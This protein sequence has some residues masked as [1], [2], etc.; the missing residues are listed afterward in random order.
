M[1]YDSLLLDHDGVL[2]SVLDSTTRSDAFR[3][4]LRR[5]VNEADIEIG[6]E[7]VIDT[8]DGGPTREEVLDLGERLGCDPGRLWTCRDEA[9]A[10]TLT[11]AARN[12]QK[13]PY[14]DLDAVTGLDYPVGIVSNNQRRVIEDILEMGGYNDAFDTVR[15]REPSIDSLATKKPEPT[16]LEEA[17]QD[18][19]V[20]NPLYV[21]DK[22][23]DVLAAERAGIDVAMLRR[24][25]NRKRTIDP[26]PTYDLDGLDAVAGL[27]Q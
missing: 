19:A 9:M 13:T 25:H 27:L 26:S 3:Q 21:G 23:S 15:A 4:H 14:D 22:Q 6:S 12:G 16:L 7:A 8:L 17:M 24:E 2:V 20:E 1:T 18:L 10:R 11:E 5:H